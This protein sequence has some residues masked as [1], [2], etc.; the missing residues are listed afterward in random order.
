VE[1]LYRPAMAD[2]RHFRFKHEKTQVKS[3][4]SPSC[5]G[6]WSGDLRKTMALLKDALVIA[7]FFTQINLLHRGAQVAKPHC[8][9]RWVQDT[10]EGLT[11]ISTSIARQQSGPTRQTRR[12]SGQRALPGSIPSIHGGRQLLFGCGR[13]G[14]L[15][16]ACRVLSYSSTLARAQE[17]P[18]AR[19]H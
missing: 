19:E 9:P 18:E 17:I 13:G 7:A 10:A 16:L 14:N 5:I 6:P 12:P 15:L 4:V 1:V 11:R 3:V 8:R 2:V